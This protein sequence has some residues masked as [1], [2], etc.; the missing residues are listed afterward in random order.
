MIISH[1]YK[2]IFIAIPKTGTHAIR[3]AV[4]P[5]MSESDMEQ[6][7]LFIEKK[8]PFDEIARIKHGHI[9]AKEIKPFL[10]EEIWNTYFKFAI[11][12]NPL[13]R[14]VSY[15]AFMNRSNPDFLLNPSPYLYNAILNKN[16]HKHI[17]FI[18][19]SEFVNDN[20]NK[21]MVDYIGRQESL[22]ASFDHVCAVTGMPTRQLEVIN[23]SEHKPYNEYLD[24]EL[25]EKIKTFYKDDFGNFKYSA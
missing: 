20:N 19:Q 1:K 5:Y 4:R 12:R 25:T 14:F 17:L 6:V 23:N 8:L 2:F 22:Q 13:D 7:G 10:S 16:N 11:V 21:L 18:P 15:C 9:K 3:F 24:N